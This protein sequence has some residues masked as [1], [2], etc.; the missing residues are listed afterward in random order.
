MLSRLLCLPPFILY[1]AFWTQRPE[2]H[3]IP[4]PG[5]H[6]HHSSSSL[7]SSGSKFTPF[8]YSRALGCPTPPA[9][10]GSL[11][12]RRVYVCVA[13]S[14]EQAFPLTL[15]KRIPSVIIEAGV[16]ARSTSC[17]LAP[18]SPM[19]LTSHGSSFHCH[20]PPPCPSAPPPH[21]SG[22]LLHLTFPRALLKLSSLRFLPEFSQAQPS[23]CFTYSSSFNDHNPPVR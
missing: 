14:P 6:R 23:A 10:P 19:P 21:T 9:S 12:N 2:C 8:L 4:V 1:G 11:Q 3:S 17:R 5:C 20:C 7:L 15:L 18:S 16:P 22:Q 13:T